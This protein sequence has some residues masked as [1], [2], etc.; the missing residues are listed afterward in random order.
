[1]PIQYRI[2]FWNLENLF[3]IDG[4]PRRTEKVA[5]TLGASIRGWSQVRLNRK[6]RQLAG[7]IRQIGEGQ[8]PDIL[9]VAEV[10]NQFVLELLV[11]ALAPLKRDY[12]VVYHETQDSRGIDV[13]FVYDAGRFLVPEPASTNTFSHYI[14]KRT[15]T[16]DIVQVNFQTVPGGRLLILLGNHWPSRKGD[17]DGSSTYRAMAGETMAY[18]HQRILEI[19][20]ESTPV[21]AMGDFNDE[22][23]DSS[24]V[25]YGL[26][27]RDPVRVLRGNKPYFYNLMW[28]LVGRGLGTYYFDG[29]A[30]LDQFLANKRLLDKESPLRV[31]PDSAAIFCPPEMVRQ[32]AYAQPLPFGGMGKPVDRNGYSD[33]FPIQVIVEEA[34]PA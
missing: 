14:L 18:F 9:G 15:A 31:V 12:R 29:P 10:E 19:R 1:M 25:D 3:D 23:F 26:A 22:P 24:L 27:L 5:R 8:G 16:R 7:I 4:S 17:E 34:D 11:K 21:L 20:G 28:P 2:A 32:G 6:I 13:A 33:H 30:V